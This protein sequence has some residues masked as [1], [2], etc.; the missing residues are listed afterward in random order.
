MAKSVSESPTRASTVVL[1]PGRSEVVQLQ[2]EI[3]PVWDLSVKKKSTSTK[4][5]AR[6]CGFVYKK[7]DKPVSQV[8]PGSPV[9]AAATQI[10]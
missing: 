10:P 4:K 6:E 7:S 9:V 2:S 3:L 8:H 1:L 5:F